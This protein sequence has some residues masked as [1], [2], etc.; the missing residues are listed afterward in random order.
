MLEETLIRSNRPETIENAFRSCGY[1][2]SI[3]PRDLWPLLNERLQKIL[4]PN[5]PLIKDEELDRLSDVWTGNAPSC[6]Y[7][8]IFSI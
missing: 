3:R 5:P 8:G 4:H 7:S 1:D 2:E 6:S